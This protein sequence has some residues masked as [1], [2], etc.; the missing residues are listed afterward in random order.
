MAHQERMTFEANH[1]AMTGLPNRALIVDR[2]EQLLGRHGRFGSEATVLFIDLDNFKMINDNLGHSVGDHLLQAV[3]TRVRR[4]LRESD[5][6]GRLGGD[7][8]IVVADCTPPLDAP[9]LI[10][11]R[12]LNAFREPFELENLATSLISVTASIGVATG[13][14]S[15]AE[16]I[17]KNADIAMYQ[18]KRAGKNCHVVFDPETRERPQFGRHPESS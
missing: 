7:E 9:D 10:C 17:V 3:A 16:E 11:R 14:R 18:A 15:P 2:I 6:L 8:F 5:T 4:V 1:D 12:V 13:A